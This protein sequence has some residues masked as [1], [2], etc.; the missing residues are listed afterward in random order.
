MRITS[1]LLLGPKTLATLHHHL[2]SS[3]GAG[4]LTRGTPLDLCS[5]THKHGLLFSLG[6]SSGL[7]GEVSIGYVVEGLV[8]FS[9]KLTGERA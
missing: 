5:G 2:G 8:D 9:T 3:L 4:V 6:F 1:P 7:G